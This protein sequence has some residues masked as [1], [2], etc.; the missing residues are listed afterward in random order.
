M[1][2]QKNKIGVIISVTTLVLFFGALFYKNYYA[3]LDNGTECAE[4]VRTFRGKSGFYFVFKYKIGNKTFKGAR[5]GSSLKIK[6]EKYLRSLDCIEIIYSKSD[7][8]NI[9]I[10]DKR[11]GNEWIDWSK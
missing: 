6:D 10:V 7:P 3:M 2:F 8:T 1:H 11:L 5:G 4:F 9:R